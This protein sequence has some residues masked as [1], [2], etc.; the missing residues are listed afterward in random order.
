MGTA[1]DKMLPNKWRWGSKGAFPKKKTQ[2]DSSHLG[3]DSKGHTLSDRVFFHPAEGRSKDMRELFNARSQSETVMNCDLIKL[4][5]V[6]H[7][8]DFLSQSNEHV[9]SGLIIREHCMSTIR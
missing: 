7:Q 8:K 1:G 2:C 6:M 4:Q 9:Y 3:F 5:E